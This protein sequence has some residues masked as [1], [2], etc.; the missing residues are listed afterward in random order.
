MT[1]TK[2]QG[3]LDRAL[4]SWGRRITCQ[5]ERPSS[6]KHKAT[7][8]SNL[9]LRKRAKEAKISPSNHRTMA[10]PTSEAWLQH[11]WRKNYQAGRWAVETRGW[12]E[13]YFMHQSPKTEN[14]KWAECGGV[15]LRSQNVGGWGRRIAHWRSVCLRKTIK[16]RWFKPKEHWRRKW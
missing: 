15:Y 5:S 16:E 6:Q 14:C 10:V 4:E 1:I 2:T 8:P 3:L 12:L 7:D 9:G 13:K 11:T